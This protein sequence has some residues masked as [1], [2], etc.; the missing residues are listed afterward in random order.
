MFMYA[1]GYTFAK[2]M[3]RE[4]YIDNESAFLLKKNISKYGLDG[5]NF[6]AEIAESKYK[7]LNFKG[8]IIRKFKKKINNFRFN[9]DFF[10][11]GRDNNKINTV[12][13]IG[14]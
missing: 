1:A 3:N 14:I 2:K 12:G 13:S 8:Y 10:I 7:F 9:K 11:E 5:F 6:L 4:L